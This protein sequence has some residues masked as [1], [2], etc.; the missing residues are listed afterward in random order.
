MFPRK[1]RG[2]LCSH[3][4]NIGNQTQSF[5]QANNA[6]EKP[7]LRPSVAEM[8]KEAYSHVQE[9]KQDAKNASG[10]EIGVSRRIA[11]AV[12]AADNLV[13]SV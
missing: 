6:D 12:T 4:L 8:V 9:V 10:L 2:Q 5:F 1:R 11:E 7:N 3:G 13:P